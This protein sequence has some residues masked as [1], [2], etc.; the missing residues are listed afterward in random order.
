MKRFLW[1]FL[2][3]TLL[4]SLFFFWGKQEVALPTREEAV[5][6]YSTEYGEDLEALFLAALDAAEERIDLAIYSFKD[7]RLIRKINEKAEEGISTRVVFDP[8]A[9]PKLFKQL[10]D[11]VE[12]VPRFSRGLTHLKL[13]VVDQ[14]VSYVGSA[15]WTRQSL[16]QY[17]NLVVG[18][19]DS[20]VGAYCV[21]KIADL[22]S[23]DERVPHRDFDPE[24]E[25]WFTPDDPLAAK[26]MVELLRSAKKT[27]QV[28]MFTFTRMDFAK[29]LVAAQQRGIQVE[30][31]VDRKSARGMGKKVA[32][33]LQDEGIALHMMGEGSLFHYKLA[34]VDEETLIEG[35]L[36]WT[37]AAF[38]KNDDCYIVFRRLSPANSEK[39]NTLVKLWRQKS[40]RSASR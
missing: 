36:N 24:L 39:L 30:V 10:S 7:E 31:F 33:Y 27:L 21:D 22:E 40:K 8:K 19:F 13:L 20:Q 1:I 34:W 16:Q 3:A 26:R 12:V 17:G 14:K 9:S 18:L 11:K 32:N 15:N 2:S 28:A 5:K 23:R 35:S 6:I 29:E 4:I 25:V 37:K 38:T